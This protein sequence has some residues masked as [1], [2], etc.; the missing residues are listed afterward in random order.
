MKKILFAMS[1]A[2]TCPSAQAQTR[3]EGIIKDS[4]TNEAEPYATVRIFREGQINK[5]V[6]MSLTDENGEISQSVNEPGN[7]LIVI[8]SIGKQEV[9]RKLS[10]KGEPSINLGY[11][12]TAD[13]T[14]ELDAIEVI[15]HKPVVKMETDKMTYNVQSDADAQSLTVLDMLRKIPMV[16][17]DAQENIAVNGSSSFKILV[18]G[19]PNIQLQNNATQI[20]KSIPAYMVQKIEILTN[21]GAKYDAEGVGG[22]LNLILHH[23]GNDGQTAAAK[24]FSG[25]ISTKLTN[26]GEIGTLYLAGQQNKWT[27]NLNSYAGYGRIKGIDIDNN[28]KQPDAAPKAINTHQAADLSNLYTGTTLGIGYEL[29]SMNVLNASFG[30]NYYNT[31]RTGITSTV[32]SGGIGGNDGSYSYNG[33]DKEK[34]F[35]IT[36]SIDW[37][38]FLNHEHTHNFTLS[39]ML[40]NNPRCQENNRRYQD[41]AGFADY[42][43]A[44]SHSD[45]HTRATE[46]TLQAD[47]TVSFAKYHTLNAGAKYIS[48]SNH[49]DAGYYV[50][51][52]HY[53]ANSV[54]YDNHQQILSTYLEHIGTYGRWST[55][56]G[57]RYEHTWEN[58]DYPQMAAQNF[59]KNYGNLVPSLTAS[60]RLGNTTNIGI[61]YALRILRP[62][63]SYLNPYRDP[64]DATAVTYGNPELDVE[65][66]HYLN[67]V[68]NH[69]GSRFAMNATLSQSF[70]NNQIASYS[71]TEET[72]RLN[73]TYGNN[74]RNRWTNLN[75]WMRFAPNT[76]T[77]IMLNGYLGY[78]D[79]RSNQL[80]AH[81][82][83]WQASAVLVLDQQLPWQ[84]KWNIGLQASTRKYDI[85]GYQSGTSVVYTMLTRSFVKGRLNISLYAMSP[86]SGKLKVRNYTKTPQFENVNTM[87]AA[88]R[89]VQLTIGWKFGNSKKQFAKHQSKIENNFG[90]NQSQGQQ[91]NNMSSGINM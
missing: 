57:L 46:H 21:P 33:T 23:E 2:F 62:G 81:N 9:Q 53:A 36:T 45:N 6:G 35:G 85:Q 77:S 67:L 69:Y 64:S 87:A 32:L 30:I 7:Y 78:G 13:A 65:N 70:C 11:I 88:L 38:H 39:Y 42:K 48:H 71:F 82:N 27:Y 37:Q 3:I 1:L 75:T 4:L 18:D 59:K 89:T 40:S 26:K 74:V 79:I 72:G 8:S 28:R 58:I 76:T 19:K 17:V 44:D 31:K 90:E 61:T 5:P 34:N 20:L 43:F 86:L 54:R 14:T 51:Q 91:I 80:K 55:R 63:I 24:G 50:Q 47:Y 12:F 60:Y 49:V 52:N 66:A 41:T 73:T 56:E 25:E 15:A 68:F 83:G 29:D 84:L 22:V 10:I 16:T